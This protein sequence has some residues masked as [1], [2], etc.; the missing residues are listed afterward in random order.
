ARGMLKAA[1]RDDD[2]VLFFEHTTLYFTEGAVPDDEEV[3]PLGR[4]DVSRVGKDITLVSIS[5]MVHHC[6]A[7]AAEVQAQDGI[8]V[9][10]IDLRSLYPLDV[11]LVLQSVQKTHRLLVV[12]EGPLIGGWGGEIAAQVAAR[13]FDDLDAPPVRLGAKRVPTPSADFLLRE[14]VPQRADVVRA[15]R[16]LAH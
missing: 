4:G 15:L 5:E 14:V 10:V 16:E 11:D 1:I 6:L 8:D 3:I 13:S 12:Q 9:E 7:A 2:P